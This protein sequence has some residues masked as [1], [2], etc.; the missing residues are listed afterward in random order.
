MS[1]PGQV[2]PR[3]G[4]VSS[5]DTRKEWDLVILRGVT[6]APAWGS[7]E[8]GLSSLVAPN[9]GNCGKTP[10]AGAGDGVW[11]AAAR[12]R[13]ALTGERP[14][15]TQGEQRLGPGSLGT[16]SSSSSLGS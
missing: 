5:G 6:K 4:G 7:C 2:A 8:R 1:L 10:R 3:G 16:G 13:W 12:S 15:A 14:Q 9:D 11:R